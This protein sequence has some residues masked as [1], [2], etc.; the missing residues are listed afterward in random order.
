MVTSMEGLKEVL[1]NKPIP[2]GAVSLCDEISSSGEKILFVIVGDLNLRGKYD[3]TALIFTDNSVTVYDGE[4]GKSST[5]LFADMSEVSAKRMYG[6]A[7][8]S[9]IMPN[10]KREVFYRYTYSTASLC[11]AAALFIEHVRG[12]ANL[13]DEA[14]VMAVVFERALSVCPKCGRT[15]LHPGAECIMCRS[16]VKVVKKLSKYLKPEIPTIILCI[17]LSLFT[18]FMAL[19]PPTITGFIVDVVFPGGSGVSSIGVLNSIASFIGDDSVT[20]LVAMI[21]CLLLTDRKSVV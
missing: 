3:E 16:K 6:N 8:L 1:Q 17:L 15:L 19:V 18:T 7:T 20:L 11:D 12:G 14:A 21:I 2:E 4:N 5:V 9:A 10:G 13:D